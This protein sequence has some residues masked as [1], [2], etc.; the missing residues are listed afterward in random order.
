MDAFSS[1]LDGETSENGGFCRDFVG[2]L[3]AAARR[4]AAAQGT[5]PIYLL[6]S[7]PPA[8]SWAGLRVGNNCHRGSKYLFLLSL[9]TGWNLLYFTARNQHSR[10]ALRI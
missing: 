7:P 4:E 5:H 10:P 6:N 8:S 3:A 1:L 9:H 2:F